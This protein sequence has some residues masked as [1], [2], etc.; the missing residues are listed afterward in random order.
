[1]TFTDQDMEGAAGFSSDIA[2]TPA[3]KAIQTRKGSRRLYGRMEQHGSW[4]REIT[5]DLKAF[6]EAQRSFF[7]ATANKDGQPTIQHRG[8][9][10]GF[11]KVLDE[12]TLAF[13][14]YVGNRQYITKGNLSE[15]PKACLI[16]V[17]YSHPSRVKFWGLARAI[18]NDGALIRSLT[19]N[20]YKAR[21]EQ[22]ISF[23]VSAWDANCPQ[24][25]PQRFE[26]SDVT[27]LLSERD[28]RIAALELQIEELR[29]SNDAPKGTPT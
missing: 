13:V 23:S 17:D 4:P 19:P 5:P 28:G 18:E 24:H 7:I 29:R 20:G 3:V 15:N 22:I 1:M 2:F 8:G 27:R 12:T 9:P 26:A 11:L 10:H 14:D 21:P 16:L 6:I 25:I